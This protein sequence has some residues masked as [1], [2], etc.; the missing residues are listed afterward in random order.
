VILSFVPEDGVTYTVAALLQVESPGQ[1]GDQSASF[2][3]TAQLT[4]VFV[5][6]GTSFASAAGAS[7]DVVVPEPG[8]AL[9]LAIGAGALALVRRGVR[10]S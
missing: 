5:P 1:E 4:R 8:A 3:S 7:Y 10:P 6:G 2:D 9:L